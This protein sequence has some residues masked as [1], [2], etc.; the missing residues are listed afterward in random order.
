MVGFVGDCEKRDLRPCQRLLDAPPC[1][2]AVCMVAPRAG[3]RIAREISRVPVCA[4]AWVL[5]SAQVRSLYN[6]STGYP[7]PRTPLDATIRHRKAWMT[8]RLKQADEEVA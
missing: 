6:Y 3:L 5:R 1:V 8:E 4:A 7:V 2:S